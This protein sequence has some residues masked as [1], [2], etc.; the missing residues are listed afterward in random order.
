MKKILILVSVLFLSF[1]I[2]AAFE[3]RFNLAPDISMGGATIT[4]FDNTSTLFL[5]PASQSKEKYYSFFSEKT[6]LFGID[7][8]ENSSYAISVNMADLGVAFFG[9]Q[10]FGND[11]YK[12]ETSLIGIAKKFGTFSFGVN[13]KLLNS[14]IDNESKSSF[15]M[16]LGFIKTFADKY[17]LAFVFKNINTPVVFDKVDRVFSTAIGVDVNDRFSF[18]VGLENDDETLF[19]MGWKFKFSDYLTVKAGYLSKPGTFTGGFAF[20]R[21]KFI[22]HYSFVVHDEL[23]NTNILALEMKL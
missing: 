10:L 18:E 4:S 9:Y 23:G 20:K 12:E 7:D 16:D 6:K 1:K 19:K 13:L 21:G 8:L 2:F 3:E 5:N 14:K 17:R 11:L 22:M 15:T